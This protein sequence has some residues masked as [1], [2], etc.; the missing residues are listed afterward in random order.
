MLVQQMAEIGGRRSRGCDGQQRRVEVDRSG[1]KKGG[2]FRP[3]LPMD[4]SASI[5]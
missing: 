2:P 1:N 3:P 5:F 4:A